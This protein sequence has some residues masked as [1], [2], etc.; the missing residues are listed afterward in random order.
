[1]LYQKGL[2]TLVITEITLPVVIHHFSFVF[3]QMQGLIGAYIPQCE[4]DGTFSSIQCHGSTGMCWCVDT[5]TGEPTSTPVM[6][7]QPECNDKCAVSF[8]KATYNIKHAC[9]VQWFII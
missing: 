6:H 8:N 5:D 1:M 4:T 3:P 7:Q 2:V 9:T